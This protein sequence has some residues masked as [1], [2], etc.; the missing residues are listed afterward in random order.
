LAL[1]LADNDHVLWLV[2]EALNKRPGIRLLK[3]AEGA[4]TDHPDQ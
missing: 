1:V 2:E 4:C 3:I